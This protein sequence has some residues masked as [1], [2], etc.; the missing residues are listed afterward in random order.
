[1][2]KMINPEHNVPMAGALHNDC[3]SNSLSKR[4]QFP[5]IS[6]LNDTGISASLR[7]LLLVCANGTASQDAPDHLNVSAAR[8]ISS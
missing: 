5:R 4:C 8:E 3:S 7:A 2:K 6:D 1:M